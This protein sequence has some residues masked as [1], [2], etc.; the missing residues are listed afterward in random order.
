[1]ADRYE[2]WE[3][4]MEFLESWTCSRCGQDIPGPRI[5]ETDLHMLDVECG[6][7][8]ADAHNK[9]IENDSLRDA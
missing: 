5:I 1:M 8:V 3:R 9:K 4:D 6:R 2:L 7:I